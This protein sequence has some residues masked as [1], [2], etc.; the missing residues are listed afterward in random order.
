MGR[1]VLKGL[2]GDAVELPVEATSART[3]TPI[4]P[5]LP[6]APIGPV[7]PPPPPSGS[8]GTGP[9]AGGLFVFAALAGIVGY[10]L[11]KKPARLAPSAPAVKAA[12]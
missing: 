11:L 9:S 12:V 3:I 2:G 6:S 1:Y 5:N 7:V 10:A 8:S 4:S